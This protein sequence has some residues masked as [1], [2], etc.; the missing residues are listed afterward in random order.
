MRT[1]QLLIPY[2]NPPVAKLFLT[3]P[4]RPVRK[5]F[6]AVPFDDGA[7]PFGSFAGIHP[8]WIWPASLS[9][10]Q[11]PPSEALKNGLTGSGY[12]TLG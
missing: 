12:V 2:L 10:Q 1:L 3:G 9:C 8:K 6:R 7:I 4:G 5:G 11:D